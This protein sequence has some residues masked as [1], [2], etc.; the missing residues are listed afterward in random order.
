[1]AGGSN[2]ER[3]VAEAEAHAVRGWDF[4]WL[5]S[6]MVTN[7][8]EWDYDSLVLRHARTSPDLVDL[9][10]GGGE[11]LAALPQR[12][13]RTVATEAWEPNLDVA[14]DRLGPLGV[15]VVHVEAAPD[16]ANQKAS[17]TRAR[18]PFPEESF[19]LVAC[20]HESFVA[21]E[22]AR[23]L[24]RGGVF[25]TQ[26]VGGDYGDF[27]RL[28]GLP[29]PQRP[30]RAW[31]LA[32]ATRQVEAAGPEVVNSAEDAQATSFSD[33]GALIWYLRAVPWTV[34]GFDA[35]QHETPLRE[36]QARLERDGP[37]IVRLPAFYLEAVK[38]AVTRG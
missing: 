8:L 37:A 7:P 36:L 33:V 24:V 15:S 22:V 11:W 1:M 32:L 20:R 38:P 29:P 6:R 9:G 18:L 12:P 14:R 30:A 21:A 35:R 5:G 2:F 31:N 34:P 10:T 19:H 17:E 4:S 25:V 3:L 26:Q 23:I 13:P 16:N 27:H 28:L